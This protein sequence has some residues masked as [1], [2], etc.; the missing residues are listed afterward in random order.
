M[1]P[2]QQTNL[3]SYKDQFNFLVNLYKKKKTSK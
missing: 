3:Y 1:T 2:V